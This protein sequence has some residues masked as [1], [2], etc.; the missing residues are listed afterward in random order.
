MLPSM[1]LNFGSFLFLQGQG[2]LV[3]FGDQSIYAANLRRRVDN[4]L[5]ILFHFLVEVFGNQ[6]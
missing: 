6:P 5:L 3:T 2:W 4:E 1:R